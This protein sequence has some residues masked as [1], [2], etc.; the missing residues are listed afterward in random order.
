MKM[1][2]GMPVTSAQN[3]KKITPQ[4]SV[5][6][7]ISILSNRSK[8]EILIEARKVELRDFFDNRGQRQALTIA[9]SKH[10]LYRERAKS[11]QVASGAFGL[12]EVR[13]A[14]ELVEAH[15]RARGSPLDMTPTEWSD[16]AYAEISEEALA[17]QMLE[18]ARKTAVDNLKRQ[19]E[20]AAREKEEQARLAGLVAMPK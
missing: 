8:K 10:N 12:A 19:L 20:E 14:H 18:S 5:N 1:A 11:Y 13:Q 3:Q 7:G 15:R 4:V 9:P 17:S 16:A 2:Q 6:S